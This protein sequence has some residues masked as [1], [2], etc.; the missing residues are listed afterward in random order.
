MAGNSFGELFKVTTF[1]ES[2]GKALG[3]TIDGMPAGINFDLD[4]IQSEMNRIRPGGNTLGTARN[5]GDEIEVIS[6]VFEGVTTGCPITLIIKNTSQKSHDYSQIKDVYRP[7]HA[8]YTYEAKFNVRDYR[9]GGRSSGRETSMRVAAGAVAK[10]LLNQVGIKIKAG[11]I[12]IGDIKAETLD[13]NHEFKNELSCPDEDASAK[14]IEL[15]KKAKDDLDSIGGVIECHVNGMIAGLGDPCFDKLDAL[16][17]HAILSIGACK[18]F[19]IGKGFESAKL[20]GSQNNDQMKMVNGEI[21]YLSNN[22]GGI[23]GGISN[24]N[25]IVFRA[26]FKPT[27]SIYKE[28]ETINK[29]HEDVTIAI[30]GRHDP[31]IVPRAVVVVEAMTALV[32]ADRYLVWRAYDAR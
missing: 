6:G 4:F 13:F 26:A 9:G 32:L 23:L 2:H 16:L 12:Q 30:K 25:E 14:M 5:E 24:G 20:Y 1:G 22:A 27:P 7:G 19:E 8:D 29:N 21:T 3:V 28:Q 10:L 11:T 18:G 17:A 15:I 31:C